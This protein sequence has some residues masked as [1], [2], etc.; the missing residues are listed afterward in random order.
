MSAANRRRVP[1]PP[2]TAAAAY[3]R[4]LV[5]PPPRTAV[6]VNCRRNI[7]TAVAAYRSLRVPQLPHTT[8][9]TETRRKPPPPIDSLLIALDAHTLN[10]DGYEPGPRP[11][12][13]TI[14]RTP[15][16]PL[17]GPMSVMTESMCTKGNQ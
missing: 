7:E 1:Q 6:A 10:L 8:A 9:A 3:R 11:K 14:S 4:R 17:S 15:L 2:L 13:P 16:G 5:S 12:E